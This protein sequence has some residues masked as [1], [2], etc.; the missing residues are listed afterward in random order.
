MRLFRKNEVKRQL[1]TIYIIGIL[2]PVIVIIFLLFNT[3]K[4]LS[5]HYESQVE[6]DNLRVKSILF[7]VTSTLFNISEDIAY[8]NELVALLSET[9]DSEA[10]AVSA[11]G[12]YKRLNTFFAKNPVVSTITVYTINDTLTGNHGNI[13][14][15]D[16]KIQ[17]KSWF[18]KAAAQPNIFFETVPVIDIFSN[19]TWELSLYR[20][21]PLPAIKS[22]AVLELRISNN[23]LKNRIDNNTIP[24]I[25]ISN[26][27]PVFYSSYRDIIGTDTNLPIEFDNPFFKYTGNLTYNNK[28]CLG[29]ISSLTPYQSEDTLF[30]ASFH[31]EAFPYIKNITLTYSLTILLF[32][33]VPMIIVHLFTKQFSQRVKTLQRAMHKASNDD[34]DIIDNFRGDDE[35]SETFSKLKIMISKIQEKE[36]N[37]YKAQIREK[38]ILNKQQ[39]ME[40][41]MLSSQIN[42]HF[43]YNTLETIRMKALTAGNREVATAIKLLGKSMRYVLENTG[44]AFTTLK[45][46]LEHIQIYL[47]IQ[48]LRFQDQV[49]YILKTDDDSFIQNYQIL[50]LLLQPIVENAFIHGFSNMEG[51]GK[52]IIHIKKIKDE[53]IKID[54]YDNGEGMSAK[55][56]NIITERITQPKG[57]SKDSIGLYNIRQRI[58]LCYGSSYDMKIYSKERFGTLVS[59]LLPYSHIYIT[60]I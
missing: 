7:D 13:H 47:S 41:K 34:Y 18:V 48:N 44:T 36:S 28:N 20:K 38:E 22:Y 43:L 50:P 49:S 15:A 26:E 16:M 8:D 11:C 35:L 52:I 10:E 9:Y 58:K 25:I 31:E 33:L 53:F 40:F 5:E 56:L 37:M 1:N 17:E 6:S 2:I 60:P 24:T 29:T 4:L 54:I 39:Q 23:Y 45:K 30:I 14:Y 27:D 51:D 21:I 3:Q 46:E 12:N 57:D 59:L 19:V 42:P 55:Q 32:L